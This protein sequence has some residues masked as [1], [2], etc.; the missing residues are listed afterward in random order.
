MYVG[1]DPGF[2]GAIGSI[3]SSGEEISVDDLPV[4]GKGGSRQFDLGALNN[5]I[6]KLKLTKAIL[7]VGLENPTTRPGEGAERC[8]RFG[9]G[10]GML[11]GILTA[12]QIGFACVSPNLWTGRLGVPGKQNDNGKQHNQAGAQLLLSYYAQAEHLI[13]GP[14]GGVKDG[15]LDALLIAHWMRVNDNG[16]N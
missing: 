15:R 12:H 2:T 3:S 4:S 6:Y 13:Y 14:R 7:V 10:I 5:L 1:M 8:K 16:K 9:E 11:K